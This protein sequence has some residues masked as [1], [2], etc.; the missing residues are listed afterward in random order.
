MKEFRNIYK[1]ARVSANM[2]Q[3]I[4]AEY[5]HTSSR[6]LS[7]YESGKTIPPDDIVCFM[8]ELYE[9]PWL[10]YEYLR[11]SSTV[12][13]KFLPIIDFSDLAKTVLRFQKE[14]GDVHQINRDMIE[15]ACDGEIDHKEEGR[16]NQVSREIWE[17]ISAGLSVVFAQQSRKTC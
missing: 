14:V 13:Q 7:D 8:I 6:S 2:S 3:E 12:G 11:T 10:A 9:A 5:L 4:A 15:I 16:W 1:I 17:M